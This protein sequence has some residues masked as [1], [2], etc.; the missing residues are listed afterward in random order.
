MMTS[1]SVMSFTG[2]CGVGMFAMYTLNRVGDRIPIYST[3]ALNCR[4]V[5]NGVWDV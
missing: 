4:C 5:E 1:A 3:P 2:A